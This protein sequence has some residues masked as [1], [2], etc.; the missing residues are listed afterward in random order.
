MHY[1]YNIKLTIINLRAH[2]FYNV[3]FN[4]VYKINILRATK[5]ENKSV[6][7]VSSQ[8]NIIFNLH[9]YLFFRHV[10]VYLL[11]VREKD[12]NM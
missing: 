7:P 4:F 10:F 5:T 6:T 11:M 1:I 12:Q 3:V 8:I 2:E 9:T